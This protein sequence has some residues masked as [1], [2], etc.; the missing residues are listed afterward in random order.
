MIAYIV[1]YE[2]DVRKI[3]DAHQKIQIWILSDIKWQD[4]VTD[5]SCNLKSSSMPIEAYSVH[6]KQKYYG[7]I[8]HAMHE[9][10]EEIKQ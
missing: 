9:Y 5:Q 6:V 2:L 8:T 7:R 4:H 1:L 3:E 10:L